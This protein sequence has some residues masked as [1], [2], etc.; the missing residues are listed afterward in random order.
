MR[1]LAMIKRVLQEML[2]DKR[3]LAMMFIAP[4]L[5]LTLMYFLFQSNNNQTADLAVRNV[6]STLIK[7]ID[8]D[9]LKIH[10]ISSDDSAKQLIHDHDYAA[11][12]TQK[13][14]KLTLTLQ[15]SNQT[16]SSIIKKSLQSGQ[17][18][19]KTQASVTALKTQKEA[20]QKL[21]QQLAV[22]AKQ[23]GTQANV[24]ASLPKQ[25]NTTTKNYSVS[26]HYIY[27]DKDTNFFDT[28]LPVMMGFVVFF[29]VF[30]IS[31]IALL[32]ERTTGTLKRLLATP[33]KRGEIITGYLS[34]YG[35]FALIQT[36]LIVFYSTY[37]FD[38][39]ILGSIWNVLLINVLMAMVA[40]T[41]GLFISTFAASEFQMMQFIPIV[42]IPQVFFSGII[43][44]DQM[45]GWLQV[46]GHIMPLYYGANAMSDVVAKGFNITQIWPNLLAL[47][48]FATLFLALNLNAMRRYREV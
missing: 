38:I 43:P 45:A 17:I 1:T 15:N 25:Q 40:L 37:V 6:D 24:Q 13:G 16:K 14:N 5:I 27:G 31:G 26:T 4:L 44:V 9:N 30:L 22:L 8:N 19:L 2:R 34:G 11:V 47:L 18:K 21:Q 48:L 12:M 39:Q 29:F 41:M 28:F 23:T 36:L 10:H 32:R 42:V 33:V 35:I 3:T 20:I 46:I 7:A